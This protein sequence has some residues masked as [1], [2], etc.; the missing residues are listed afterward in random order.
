[1]YKRYYDGYGTMDRSTVQDGGE[2]IIPK[3]NVDY[4]ESQEEI[5]QNGD[6]QVAS[7]LPRSAGKN[8]LGNIAIDDII[9]IG[10]ILL[11]IKD[12][13]EDSFLIIILAVIFL[14]GFTDK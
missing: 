11:V 3:A 5:T 13:P 4:E 1:M 7:V 6:T 9:L 8:L 14:L 12:A 2:V 10:V